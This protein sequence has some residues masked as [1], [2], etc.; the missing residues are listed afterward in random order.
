MAAEALSQAAGARHQRTVEQAE[1]A[2]RELEPRAPRSASRPLPGAPGSRVSGSTPSPSCAS[3]SSS[4][5][6]TH[7]QQPAGSRRA[8][9]PARRR[10]VSG[11]SRCAP[12]T[13]R[14]GN[15]LRPATSRPRC[16]TSHSSRPLLAAVGGHNGDERSRAGGISLSR[17]RCG[18]G[19]QP[20]DRL[21]RR[22]D[23]FSARDRVTSGNTSQNGGEGDFEPVGGPRDRSSSVAPS[24][25]SEL[26]LI[27][28]M[29][30]SVDGFIADREGAFGWTVPSDELFRL[31]VSG[32]RVKREMLSS[33]TAASARRGVGAVGDMVVVRAGARAYL[34][35]RSGRAA[36]R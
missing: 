30:V 2:L 19:Q 7:P 1:R 16:L 18:G 36:G 6:T 33:V 24:R 4:C 13:S 35:P 21:A 17:C 9:G 3:G 10:W 12:R 5:A 27:H 11:L 34:G 23:A 25:R 8:S 15:R 26:M 22:D 32:A 28:S 14:A 20:Y 29:S 31:S